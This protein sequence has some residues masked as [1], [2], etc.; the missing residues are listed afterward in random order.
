MTSPQ[1][2]RMALQV[3]MALAAGALGG[4]LAALVRPRPPAAYAS[5]YQAPQPLPSVSRDEP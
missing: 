2:R 5:S 3:I 1:V 4:Y